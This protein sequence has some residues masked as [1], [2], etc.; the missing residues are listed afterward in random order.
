LIFDPFLWFLCC[1]FLDVLHHDDGQGDEMALRSARLA[2]MESALAERQRPGELWEPL[3]GSDI[4]C[5]ACA[6]ECRLSDGA[7][8]A[9]RVRENRGGRLLVPA[10]Y[11]SAAQVEPIEKKPLFHVAPGARTLS[12]GM[13]GC[14]MRCA[15]CQNWVV[16][17][18]LRDESA[19]SPL[20]PIT[21]QELVAR[22]LRA[23]AQVV[24]ATYNEPL[25]TAEWLVD[26]FRAAR[27]AGLGTGVVSNGTATPAVLE[28][29]RPW[30]D[31]FRVDLKCM[32]EEGYRWLGGRL[33]HVLAGIRRIRQLGFWL[34]VV[35][36]LIPGFNDAPE[37]IEISARFLAGVSTK[38]PWHITRFHGDYRMR[39]P[40]PTRPEDAARAAEIAKNAGLDHVYV[41]GFGGQAGALE[42]TWC[43]GCGDRLVR[44]AGYATLECRV[45]NDDRCPTC[46]RAIPGWWTLG[47]QSSSGNI[48]HAVVNV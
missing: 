37:Q 47:I 43:P 8:G 30:V 18:T 33:E 44:R 39:D 6:Y 10:G 26:V 12:F 32:N 14:N 31:F 34:E 15:Y 13:L 5:T 25:V 42:D 36:P 9:C 48:P 1:F 3:E 46:R 45:S 22:A 11:V 19:V 24:I 4:R 29:L 16:S 21:A 2:Q 7:V 40:R 28:Y 35:T 23:S 38:I 20:F 27:Q 17:Q 41:G